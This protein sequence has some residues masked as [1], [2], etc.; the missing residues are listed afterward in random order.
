MRYL[1]TLVTMIAVVLAACDGAGPSA[2]LVVP[3][4]ASL[5][6]AAEAC[7]NL[8][9]TV[10]ARFVEGKD[11]DIEG[12]L[13]NR[14]GV[15][16][17]DAFAWIDELIP[18]GNGA[19]GVRM[20][21]RYLLDGSEIDTEDSGVLTPTAPPVFGFNN[22]LEIVGGTHPFAGATGFLRSHGEV[23]FGTGQIELMYH[24]R[25]CA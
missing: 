11:W 23:D 4:H 25:I 20:R 21:H 15:R 16:I 1:G 22:R 24:G 9:G 18:H 13:F 17:G 3:D 6:R 7:S 12:D 14:E 10:S 19:I 2:P 8:S 5:S